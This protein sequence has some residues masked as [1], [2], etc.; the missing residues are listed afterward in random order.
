VG[1][2][3]NLVLSLKDLQSVS[4]G[5]NAAASLAVNSD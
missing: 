1:V 4:S 5:I 2:A 3:D